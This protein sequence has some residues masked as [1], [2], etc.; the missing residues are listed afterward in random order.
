MKL[1]FKFRGLRLA[2]EAR[3]RMQRAPRSRLSLKVDDVAALSRTEGK[4]G[5]RWRLQL[6]A[7]L[8]GQAGD[9]T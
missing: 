1:G 5:P 2:L 9:E 7:A 4:P 8:E 3:L 6:K